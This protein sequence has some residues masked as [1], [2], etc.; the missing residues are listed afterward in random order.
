MLWD[1]M[2]ARGSFVF[3]HSCLLG[4]KMCPRPLVG[5]P[6]FL[7]QQGLLGHVHPETWGSLGHDLG[8]CRL[9]L[10]LLSASKLKWDVRRESPAAGRDSVDGSLAFVPDVGRREST[11]TSGGGAVPEGWLTQ[12][13]SQRAQ[14]AHDGELVPFS[15]QDLALVGAR[16]WSA[17]H[18]DRSAGVVSSNRRGQVLPRVLRPL[19]QRGCR[20]TIQYTYPHW[21][22]SRWLQRSRGAPRRPVA[23][24]CQTAEAVVFGCE[25]GENGE[26][27]QQSRQQ[28]AL[29]RRKFGVWTARGGG[30]P[31]FSHEVPEN[32]HRLVGASTL[33]QRRDRSNLG[34]VRDNRA[35]RKSFSKV[36]QHQQCLLHI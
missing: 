29:S 2:T 27:G 25:I 1:S 7:G 20:V 10:R 14:T 23:V 35:L 11:G 13:P 30:Q 18:E 34:D 26:S 22:L 21:E 28:H 33:E 5:V 3:G 36:R 15:F 17:A 4:R 12:S 16:P 31:G 6:H 32:G 24:W 8:G 9:T 19:V